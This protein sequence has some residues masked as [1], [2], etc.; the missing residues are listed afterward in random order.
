MPHC[1]PQSVPF[2]GRQSHE[3]PLRRS[4]ARMRKYREAS[5]VVPCRQ[6]GKKKAQEKEEKKE[7]TGNKKTTVLDGLCEAG[8]L[9]TADEFRGKLVYPDEMDASLRRTA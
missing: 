9:I 4:R 1:K 6:R 7:T 2:P 5:H 8:L 3:A